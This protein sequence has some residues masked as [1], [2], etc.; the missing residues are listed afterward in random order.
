[1]Y[2]CVYTGV[3]SNHIALSSNLT[4]EEFHE[5]NESIQF[6]RAIL[7]ESDAYI[8]VSE[9]CKEFLS[10]ASK[11]GCGQSENFTKINRYFTNYLNSFYMWLTFHNHN[12][13][14]EKAYARLK[15]KY[16][17]EN[18]TY[19]LARTLRNYTTHKAFAISKISFDVLNE[20]TSFMIEPA[21]ILEDNKVDKNKL[22]K[23]HFIH[24]KESNDCLNAVQFTEDFL[25]FFDKFQR[26]IWDYLL[27]DI[28]KN[29]HTILSVIPSNAPDCFNMSIFDEEEKHVLN[30]GRYMKL[31]WDR[32]TIVY[33]SALEL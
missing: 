20:Y 33:P 24:L 19:G 1:M 15:S 14:F 26:E 11:I 27:P 13:L 8:V 10:A 6:L 23:E 17:N 18:L 5:T 21:L 29:L 22:A 4:N 31:F 9:N 25:D 7:N 28:K 30:V 3:S 32:M 16:Q 12:K 2:K